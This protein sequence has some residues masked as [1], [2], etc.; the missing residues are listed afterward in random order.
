MGFG[1]GE[2]LGSAGA[3][4]TIAGL[5]F[6]TAFFG[7]FSAG[8]V[9]RAQT[10]LGSLNSSGIDCGGLSG[11]SP[12]RQTGLG[13]GR[14]GVQPGVPGTQ[15][16]MSGQPGVPGTQTVLGQPG[17]PGTQIVSGQGGCPG[18]PQTGGG[19]VV[20]SFGFST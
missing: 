18:S 11:Q 2:A 20:Q 5:G 1:L 9:L 10:T 3:A 12:V 16:N 19:G 15:P 7:V 13:G 17:V 6:T 4:A 14:T 8:F